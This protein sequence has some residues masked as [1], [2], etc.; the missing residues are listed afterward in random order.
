MEPVTINASVLWERM[1]AWDEELRGEKP[2]ER[3]QVTYGT[4]LSFVAS[5]ARR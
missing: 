2:A 1:A 5:V 4:R 3:P